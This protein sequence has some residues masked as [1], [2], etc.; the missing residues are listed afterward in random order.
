MITTQSSSF[1]HNQDV[2][3]KINHHAFPEQ[4][5]KLCQSSSWRG[6]EHCQE[7]RS[8]KSLWW[9]RQHG[10]KQTGTWIFI[11]YRAIFINYANIS[12][13]R[14]ISL[15]REAKL[16]AVASSRATLVP[17][18][19]VERVDSLLVD[20][21]Q[22]SKR[23]SDRNGNWMCILTTYNRSYKSRMKI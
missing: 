20:M 12:L 3:L 1:N 18:R 14:E 6:W 19:L 11:A 13:G 7:G 5:R 16:P 22:K 8:I 17:R 4:P 9:F 2:R 10:S 23:G 15:L 21:D